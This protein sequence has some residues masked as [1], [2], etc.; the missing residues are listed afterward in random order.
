MAS[1]NMYM[2]V[3]VHEVVS[4]LKVFKNVKI[5]K[6]KMTLTVKLIISDSEYGTKV[7]SICL[8]RVVLRAVGKRVEINQRQN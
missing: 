3:R 5:Y 1:N 8:Y 2:W 4:R 6:K 7:V